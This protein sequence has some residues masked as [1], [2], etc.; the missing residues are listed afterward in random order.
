MN[1]QHSAFYQLILL[2]IGVVL[3]LALAAAYDKL[4]F[5]LLVMPF[6]VIMLALL[7]V[8]KS[9]VTEKLMSFFES[10]GQRALLP[11]GLF[12]VISFIATFYRLSQYNWILIQ[13]NPF[14]LPVD[15]F[16]AGCASVSVVLLYAYFL[17]GPA[18]TWY[19]YALLQLLG[20]ISLILWDKL[21]L[22]IAPI[23][24]FVLSKFAVRNNKFG[25]AFL[26]TSVIYTTGLY[27][28]LYL[29]IEFWVPRRNGMVVL[30]EISRWWSQVFN[31]DERAFTLI[32]PVLASSV[33]ALLVSVVWLKTKSRPFTIGLLF[34]SG[35]AAI[36]LYVPLLFRY[37]SIL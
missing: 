30:K 20:G 33:V 12:F 37:W 4:V 16:F 18:S 23:Y 26:T 10:R 31:N 21:V 6:V 1:K 27:S 17:A 29:M 36:Y 19:I 22:L 13:D 34:I 3:I 5:R 14:P 9:A 15:Y 24:L 32:Y 28:I 8:Q 25:I 2:A 35:A 7:C 11:L